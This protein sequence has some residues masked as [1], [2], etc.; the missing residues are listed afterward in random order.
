VTSRADVET[1]Y[2][3]R[4]RQR[5]QTLAGK[6]RV[7]ARY[8][9][10]RVVL[11]LIIAA[12]AI[13]GGVPAATWLIAP[14]VAFA[15]LAVA[16]A[17]LLNLRDRAAS[18]VAFYERGLAR[19]T[20]QWIG[21]GRDGRHL[22]PEHHLYAEDLDI[23]GRGSLFEL[24][25]T[26]RTHAGEETLAR[27]LLAPAGPE[28]VRARQDAVRELAG[29]LDLRERVAVMGDALGIGV[30]AK[31]LRAW[32]ATPIALRS[33]AARV[34]LALLVATT[35]G[36]LLWWW[37]N[38]G[39]PGSIVALLIV[40]QMAIAQ[41]YKTRVLS[42]IEAVDEPAHDLELLADLLRTIETE[43]MTAARL[44]ALQAAVARTGRPASAEIGQLSRMIGW[45]SARHNVY[46]AIPAG[47]VMWATQWAFAIESWRS[48][49]GVHIPEWLDV[50]GEFEALLA[51]ATFA[52]EHPDEAV[53][54]T[55]GPRDGSAAADN[56]DDGAL[57][58]AV[59]LKHP[60]LPA[61]AVGNTVTIGGAAPHLLIVSGSNM[62]GKSTLLR[63]LG[64]NA[65]LAQMGAPVRA[66]AFRMAPLDIGAAI[67]VQDSLVDGRSRFMAE[68]TR[69]K[70]IV[71]LTAARK[72][73]VLFLLDEILGGTNS[74]DRR[75]GSEALLAGLV[76][77]GAV[78]LVTT[79]DLALSEIATR[80]P[81]RADNVHFVDRFED[82]EL[83][84]DYR[85][86]PGIV[87][88]SN[89]LALMRSIGLDV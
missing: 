1:E 44:C 87:Q 29:R 68:I 72:G 2:R 89:A 86:R 59:D 26:T 25:A 4:L 23:F 13:V 51:L 60:T 3:E 74:H 37:W 40:A 24:L 50:V 21:H 57:I 80:L 76:A 41:V 34:A 27:W 56:L 31:V 58:A 55:V 18:A 7:H 85:L 71:D 38:G 77:S 62:S 42:V 6:E 53:F 69:L 9:F 17:R 8:A 32:A 39:V 65:V 67:R 70:E 45:L 15:V 63:A 12:I 61:S 82:G 73:A 49:A 16:H 52:A 30:H 54:P 66:A 75:I 79:H 22:A 78:G 84:F 36:S 48:R 81:G 14:V 43:P 5:R 46:F 83:A 64:A 28:V 19:V 20:Y 35:V 47:L 10:A 88:T 33:A 11:F